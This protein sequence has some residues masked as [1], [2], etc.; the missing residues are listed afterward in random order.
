MYQIERYIVTHQTYDC[1]LTV[2]KGDEHTNYT[3]VYSLLHF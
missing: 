1:N 3:K 2:G